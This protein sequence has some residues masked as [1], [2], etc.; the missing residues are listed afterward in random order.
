MAL[1]NLA[2]TICGPPASEG[3]TK[4]PRS[5]C[6]VQQAA[7]ASTDIDPT[8]FYAPEHP[9]NPSAARIHTAKKICSR[10]SVIKQCLEFAM[11]RNER[12]GVWGGLTVAERRQL[13]RN[14]RI[15]GKG[16]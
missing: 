12:F 10:C 7:C 11:S 13:H 15:D 3:A 1:G 5:L 9:G 8:I 14:H 6:W 4:D 16:T 2:S